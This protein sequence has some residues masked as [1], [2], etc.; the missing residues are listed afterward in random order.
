MILKKE[1]ESKNRRNLTGNSLV[2]GVFLQVPMSTMFR[3]N[4]SERFPAQTISQRWALSCSI[5]LVY[6]R[7]AY[8]ARIAGSLK[9]I[10]ECHSGCGLRYDRDFV[11]LAVAIVLVLRGS[12]RWG[13]A[14]IWHVADRGKRKL[15]RLKGMKKQ[16]RQ[17]QKE[18]S[19]YPTRIDWAGVISLIALIFSLMVTLFLRHASQLVKGVDFM[20]VVVS[21]IVTVLTLPFPGR[22]SRIA[23]IQAILRNNKTANLR[24]GFEEGFLFGLIFPW[25]SR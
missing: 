25:W 24:R 20:V 16:S 3:G 2:S 9:H 7:N 5:N 18:K 1:P 8:W 13:I 15:S 14:S 6:N 19:G 12:E 22:E 21:L 10:G 11:S 4:K 23:K 17:N